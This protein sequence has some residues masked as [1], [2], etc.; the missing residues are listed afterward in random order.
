[1]KTINNATILSYTEENNLVTIWSYRDDE[2]P[3][4]GYYQP[5]ISNPKPIV[6]DTGD[7]HIVCR[8]TEKGTFYNK[9]TQHRKE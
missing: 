9:I 5:T 4:T 6:G 1:M 2:H 8:K 3:I 7:F